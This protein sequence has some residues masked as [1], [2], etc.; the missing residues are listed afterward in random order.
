[1]YRNELNASTFILKLVDGVYAFPECDSDG[2]IRFYGSIPKHFVIITYG[3]HNEYVCSCRKMNCIHI[4]EGS[5]YIPRDEYINENELSE[6]FIHDLC[7][8]E[9]IVGFF[10][11][12]N[13]SFGVIKQM[14]KSQKCLVCK[15][16]STSCLH[17]Q[18]FIEL[19]PRQFVPE[20]FESITKTKI[21]YPQSD[22]SAT[23]LQKF[24]TTGYPNKLIPLYSAQ[25]LCMCGNPFINTDPITAGWIAK[26][27][28]IIHWEHISISADVYYRPTSRC[29][30]RQPYEGNHDLIFNSTNQHLFS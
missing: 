24:R 20:N 30:C 26:K 6:S 25:K 21:N 28:A 17:Y 3:D 18:T 12:A 22:T 23:L 27:D 7:A 16:N 10:S 19:C 2:K 14:P 8:N 5:I 4:S 1:M 15:E 11:Y 9:N 13:N 29:N